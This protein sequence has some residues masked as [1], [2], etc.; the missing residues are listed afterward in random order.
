MGDEA[1]NAQPLFPRP[2]SNSGWHQR[3]GSWRRTATRRTALGY[4]RV[5]TRDHETFGLFMES[6]FDAYDSESGRY[7]AVLKAGLQRHGLKLSDVLAVTRDLQGLWAIC[8]V[9][10]FCADL[11]GMF[12]KRIEVDRLIP[13]SE[14]TSIR[15][16][17]TGPRT[18]RIVLMHGSEKLAQIDP[19]P[20]SGDASTEVTAAYRTSIYR[21][22]CAQLGIG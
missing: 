4:G 20:P 6:N 16:E 17:P 19:S 2:S 21:L 15:R 11:R 5:V 18:S 14:V 22:L 12:R 7:P 1:R 10:V 9:G 3:R 8:R 13:Y